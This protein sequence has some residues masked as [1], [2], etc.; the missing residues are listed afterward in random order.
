MNNARIAPHTASR[1]NVSVTWIK[2]EA[3]RI[4]SLVRQSLEYYAA[5]HHDTAL[6]K[7]CH[8][9]IHQINGVMEMFGLDTVAVVSH[10]METLID[11]LHRNEL[12]PEDR[13]LDTLRQAGKTA[14]DYL[15]R[16]T[17]DT[18][19]NLLYLFPTYRNLLEARGVQHVSEKNLLLSDLSLRLPAPAGLVSNAHCTPDN[20]ASISRPRFQS[21][22]LKWLRNPADQASL[23]QMH[24]IIRHIEG[25]IVS[26][27][28]KVFWQISRG[29]LDSLLHQGIHIDLPVRKLCA[30]IEQ[31]IGHLADSR[32]QVTAADDQIMDTML[33][34][35][36]R[37]KPV[38][39]YAQAISHTWD[40]IRQTTTRH[41]E[42]LLP[43]GSKEPVCLVEDGYTPKP[44][45][46]E[47]RR[48]LAEAKE[49]WTE[50]SSDTRHDLT[51]FVACTTKLRQTASPVWP[52]SLQ[53]LIP[54][55]G[56][57]AA[58]LRIQPQVMST[59]L[60]LEV[61]ASLLLLENALE[62]NP[63]FSPGIAQQAEIL[64]S[65]LRGLV[66]HKTEE[67][68]TSNAICV[69]NDNHSG[70]LHNKELGEQISR[71]SLINLRQAEQILDEFFRHPANRN[72]LPALP[73]ISS[74]L[75]AWKT[76]REN[77]HLREALLRSLHTL[78]GNARIGGAIRL[79][80]LIH[81]MESR[82]ENATDANT[83]SPL[84][85]EELEAGFD[86]VSEDIERLH[87]SLHET[88]AA[89]NSGEIAEPASGNVAPPLSPWLN[90][91]VTSGLLP[92]PASSSGS[93]P[94]KPLLRVHTRTIDHLID[95]STAIRTTQAR[96]ESEIHGIALLLTDL[97][98]AISELEAQLSRPGTQTGILSHLHPI[99]PDS[100][101]VPSS[102]PLHHELAQFHNLHQLAT[103]SARHLSDIC[104][105]I[106][107]CNWHRHLV[108][109][110]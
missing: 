43:T 16:L 57:T 78:K 55:I 91:P 58:H 81:N 27:E 77:H 84:L 95:T 10:E 29:F 47:I 23:Y 73:E 79:G 72:G 110:V 52:S 108:W 19:D 8:D 35:I 26:S 24:D 80:E 103:D 63:Y 101:G 21:A 66:R 48:T 92:H 93:G 106:P 42:T 53:K 75:R 99:L 82:I 54:V 22:L 18:P 96:L 51:P 13:I 98:T 94:H 20:L 90:Q 83:Q 4:F 25:S 46:E 70:K 31:A 1:N 105:Q 7:T 61:A 50:Y 41:Q 56:G 14:A 38:S 6:I 37:S 88:S 30:K 39:E 89:G 62:Q 44:V 65:R 107:A 2:D 36:A 97:N 71:E 86:R 11:L 32:H 67:V 40:Q 45:L 100:L 12:K 76:D 49:A 64:V 102:Q 17:D 28:Q 15:A 69:S 68:F 3:E 60:A 109:K 74:E 9:H 59:Q 85:F 5:N 87:K 104:V 33:S 34:L